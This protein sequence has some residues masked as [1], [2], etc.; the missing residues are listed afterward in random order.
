MTVSP[1]G[2]YYTQNEVKEIVAYAQET[3]DYSDTRN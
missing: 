2:G 3:Y 1:Y